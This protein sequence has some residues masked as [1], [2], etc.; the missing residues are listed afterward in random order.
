MESKGITKAIA[1]LR[2]LVI[3]ETNQAKSG[4][5]GMA[6]D[7]APALYVLYRDFLKADPLHPEW[8]NRDRFILSSGHV[9]ALLYA[10]LHLT[11]YDVSL[12]DLRSFRQLGSKTPGHP[13]IGVTPGVDASSGPLG[14]GF[15]Q[16]IGFAL[17]ERKVRHLYP[18]GE[19]LCSHK[20]YCLV[21]DG[22]LEEGVSQE[23]LSFAGLEKLD[24][25]IVIYDANGSTLD[26]LTPLSMSENQAQRFQAAN[27][28]VQEVLDAN[29][30]EALR[31]AFKKAQKEEGK[32]H[33]IIVH[34]RIGYGS[35]Y[36][37]SN[38]AH[39]TPLGSEKGDEA[40]KF[41][42]LSLEPFKVEDEAYN[43]A[44]RLLERGSESYLLYE[45]D[46]LEYAK[47]YPEAY[48]DFLERNNR[49]FSNA[50][51][52]LEGF[53]L[54][55]E[56]AGRSTS[57]RI[58]SLI[59]EKEQA[60]LGGAADVASSLKTV[61]PSHR[62]F[63]PETLEGQML[64]Y[65]VREFLMGAAQN[66]I[67][68]H[69]G[70]LSFGGTFLVFADYLKAA[71]RLGALEKVPALWLFSHDSLAVG[72][73]GPTHQPI[74]Q[75]AM[76]RSLPNFVT[77]RPGDAREVLGAYKEALTA[78]D[79]ATAII[80]T[81]QNLPLLA[82]TLE[83]GVSK[84]A[85]FVHKAHNPCYQLLASGSEL[86][87]ALNIA[88][89]LAKDGYELDVVS[90]PSFELFNKMDKDYQ[91]SILRLPH[92]K[93]IS[94]EMLS[95]FGWGKYASI[96]LGI[97]DFGASGPEKDVISAYKFD[98]ESLYTRIKTLIA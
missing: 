3:D 42:G 62:Y 9:S 43:D 14:Q 48:H 82:N 33:L 61:L 83:E 60:L 53:K 11:G 86:H 75:L 24:R 34:S 4:H 77:F 47:K 68:M 59:S 98:E 16:A 70:L 26:G 51:K 65:G 71:L 84:G 41:F 64:P 79:H 25:L 17:A 27:W 94:L 13:E 5:P 78:K 39:G 40:K 20:T 76:L 22:C 57:G 1:S 18:E 95:T 7:I 74:E 80:L 93:R 32:P 6:L 46:I 37:G 38:K 67:M 97:D 91:D 58:L 96:N 66:G 30:I 90:V 52:A 10:L 12:E 89:R 28:D 19:R 29:D 63:T 81:R 35:A 31:S 92:E 21:G 88:D 23:A 73:D 69:G 50:L 44:H 54:L 87:I 49:N 36:E 85:Y 72:E 45:K 15:A 8:Y 55:P 56:E 2:G